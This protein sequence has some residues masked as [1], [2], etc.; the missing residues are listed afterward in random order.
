MSSFNIVSVDELPSS[1][2]SSTTSVAASTT[3]VTLLAA[4]SERLGASVYNDADRPMYLKLGASA[5]TTSYTVRVPRQFLY[6]VPF[7]YTGIIEAVWGTGVTGAARI[8]EY[9]A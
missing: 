8:T 3:N 7:S 5:S 9:E 4:N 1:S 2:S 6:E